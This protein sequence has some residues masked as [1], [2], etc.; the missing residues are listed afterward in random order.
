M[1]FEKQARQVTHGARRDT[2]MSGGGRPH[3]LAT[4]TSFQHSTRRFN[5]SSKLV[6]V[7]RCHFIFSIIKKIL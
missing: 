1:I 5:L 3:W 4:T 7:T 6:V 2:R